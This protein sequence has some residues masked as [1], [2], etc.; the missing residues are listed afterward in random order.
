M[1]TLYRSWRFLQD[2]IIGTCAAILLIVPTLLAVAEIFRRYVFGAT[3]YWGQDAVTYFLISGAF[4][5]FG[6]SQAQRTHL[7]V[8]VLPEWLTRIGQARLS[9]AIR[10]SAGLLALLFVIGFVWWGLPTAERTMR[11]GRLTESMV[12]PLWPFQ[13]VLL[14]GMG[15]FGITLMF[16]L[17]RDTLLL[18]TGRDPFPWD[19]DHEEFEL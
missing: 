7:A 10:V 9:Y 17:Y 11:L 18:V 8:T 4:L 15:T 2:K 6:A 1:D 5:Y 3:F 16:Q 12:L 19:T 14:V 13:Y